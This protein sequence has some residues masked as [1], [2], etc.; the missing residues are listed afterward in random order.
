M[1]KWRV[2]GL[3][4]GPQLPSSTARIGPF[5][6][7][8]RITEQQRLEHL[9]RVTELIRNHHL[10]KTQFESYSDTLSYT[11]PIENVTH[12]K[13]ELRITVEANDPPQAM[14]SAVDEA[15]KYLGALALV[16]GEQRYQFG[17]TVVQQVTAATGLASTAHVQSLAARVSLY[18][19]GTLTQTDTK[20]A[21]TLLKLSGQNKAVSRAFGY[22]RA[23]WRLDDI[24]RSDPAVQKAIVSNCYL[25]LEAISE[26]VTKQW[27]KENRG[28]A[29]DDQTQIIHA[30]TNKLETAQDL[31]SQLAA[32]REANTKLNRAER[33]FQDLKLETA[34]QQLGLSKVQIS[35]AQELYD[36]RNKIN[37]PGSVRIEKLDEWILAVNNPEAP[38]DTSSFGRAELT[39]MAYLKAYVKSLSS[40]TST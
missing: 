20:T 10:A 22:L 28:H 17:P 3:V 24:G 4:A 26:A 19:P 13:H 37:H 34:G 12:S 8:Q 31:P 5:C 29:L 35:S 32:I 23:A 6:V 18:Y 11:L 36:M 40:A 27:R 7:I 38:D 1:P 25:V 33:N 2:T 30:L 15:A 14:I 16:V 9:E 21:N 39:A